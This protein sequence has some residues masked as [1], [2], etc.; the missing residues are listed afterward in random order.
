MVDGRLLPEPVS[1]TAGL[2]ARRAAVGLPPMAE[3]V[4]R[5]Q[6]QFQVPV[7]WPPPR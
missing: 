2:D 5:M 3:Y 6:E 7:V 1:D 4:R